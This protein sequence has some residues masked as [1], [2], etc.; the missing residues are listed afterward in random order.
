MVEVEADNEEEAGDMIYED[1][2]SGDFNVSDSQWDITE[3]EETEIY[4][5]NE[6]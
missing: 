5:V 2:T 1:V 6:V 4:E 3:I